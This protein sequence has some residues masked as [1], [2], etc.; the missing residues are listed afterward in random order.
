MRIQE[1]I[2]NYNFV[3]ELECITPKAHWQY[4]LIQF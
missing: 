3:L 4:K 2:L 1:F